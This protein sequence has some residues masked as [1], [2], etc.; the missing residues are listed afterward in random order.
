M[1]NEIQQIFADPSKYALKINN[2]IVMYNNLKLILNK[3]KKNIEI[4]NLTINETINLAS[5]LEK[6]NNIIKF[7]TIIK[8]YLQ[9]FYN[10]LKDKNI[11]TKEYYD[12]NMLLLDTYIDYYN[13]KIIVKN[14]IKSIKLYLNYIKL[15]NLSTNIEIKK[16]INEIKKPMNT[17]DFIFKTYNFIEDIVN[18][19]YYLITNKPDFIL[20]YDDK[21]IVKYLNETND[22]ALLHFTNTKDCKPNDIFDK[23]VEKKNTDKFAIFQQK[24]AF[25]DVSTEFIASEEIFTDNNQE[26]IYKFQFLINVMFNLVI[27]KYISNN[28]DLNTNSIHFIYKGGTSMKI[29]YEKYKNYFENNKEIFNDLKDLFKRSDSD[30]AL[31]IDGSLPK[32]NYM[33]HYY[34]LNIIVYNV[35]N[36]ISTYIN[37]NLTDLLPINN[38]NEKQMMK[39]LINMNTLLNKVNNPDI[40]D[41][42][43]L[44]L[45]KD[46]KEFIG[47]NICNKHFFTEKLP[48]INRKNSYIFPN[49][50]SNMDTEYLNK[51]RK[52]LKT[53]QITTIGR[54]KFFVSFKEDNDKI[55]LCVNDINGPI[56]DS[57]IYQYYNETNYFKT[58]T[59]KINYFTLHRVKLN[60]ILYYRTKNNKYGVIQF[61][62]EL[63]D[64]PISTYYDH[65]I[66]INFNDSIKKYSYKNYFHFKSYTIY[67]FIEDINKAIFDEQN[68]PWHDIKYLKKINRLV[69][70]LMIYI[71][72]YYP[73]Y[74]NIFKEELLNMLKTI[75]FTYK[76]NETI[77][78][79]FTKSNIIINFLDNLRTVKQKIIGKNIDDVDSVQFNKM[80]ETIKNIVTKFVFFEEIE[81]DIEAMTSKHL[82]YVNFLKK[83]TKYKNKYIKFKQNL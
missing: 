54:E 69:L 73:D 49:D 46:I 22:D 25:Y 76:F 37:E 42:K 67:G 70:L 38:I 12:E 14:F 40:K 83:Y 68:L 80:I 48:I 72:K 44:L 59:G 27:A 41:K 30:Y 39:L 21:N 17:K 78:E 9:Y 2:L 63:I 31:Y 1:D 81:S 23:T 77:L 7:Y 19:K 34:N 16:P 11:I 43:K 4:K 57:G 6:I 55:N 29:I 3:F 79:I 52:Q 82:E 8:I 28:S 60:I 20:N 64:L 61:P 15:N 56:L 26:L 53:N 65:K 13:S 36:I 47:V 33:K 18:N 5:N 35:L 51:I 32:E 58:E 66:K 75:D 71:N 50:S 62:A 24:K 10:M 45:F 74:A